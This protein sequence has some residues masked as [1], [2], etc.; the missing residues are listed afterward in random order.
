[1]RHNMSDGQII[2]RG[3]KQ[4]KVVLPILKENY[5]SALIDYIRSNDYR[6]QVGQTLI[7]LA[8]EFGFCYGVD[9]AIQY[10]YETRIQ[11]P[12]RRIFLTGEIIHNPFVN[13]KLQDIGIQFI[14]VDGEG[15]RNYNVLN[16]EDIVIIP[17]FGVT[18][19]ELESLKKRGCLLV[20]T[21]CGSVMNVWKSVRQYARDGFTSVIHGKYYHEET[22]ATA[23]QARSHGGHY[24]IVLNHKQAEIVAQFVRGHLSKDD[25][26]AVF[27]H[28]VSPG[29]DPDVH[30]NRIGLA[31]QTTMLMKES[32]EIQEILRQA[33]IDRYGVDRLSEHFRAFETICSATQD[34]QDAVIQLLET[35]DIDLMIV[36]GGFNSSNTGSL[37]NICQQYVPSYHIEDASGLLDEHRIYHK[38][39]LK[40]PEITDIRF[41]E[42]PLSIGVTAGASTPNSI[43]ADVIL[44]LFEIRKEPVE[45][46]P[47]FSLLQASP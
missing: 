22:R 17:A 44:R 41:P 19:D 24:L 39:Y 21:T 7:H 2:Q 23:S 11:F 46:A 35:N 32:L 37:L 47:W 18:T 27:E 16:P 12:D 9:R 10:A 26:M 45:T 43:V 25:F 8:R 34:R 6:I 38:P 42:G 30:L 29:F 28:A 5:A 31:N 36:I 15:R 4:K 14:P 20:D 13:K 33:Y 1:M 3:F 40:V